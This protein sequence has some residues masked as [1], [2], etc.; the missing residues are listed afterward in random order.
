MEQ[1]EKN[2]KSRA[3]ILTMLSPNLPVRLRRNSLN[4]ICA[5]GNLSQRA[6]VSY[7]KNKDALYLSCVHVLF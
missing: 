6:F 5:R 4:Q 7:Y 2:Q 3:L 1:S